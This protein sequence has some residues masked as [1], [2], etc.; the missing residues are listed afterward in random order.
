MLSSVLSA[1]EQCSFPYLHEQPLSVTDLGKDLDDSLLKAIDETHHPQGHTCE[2]R[3]T[4]GSQNSFTIHL[5][6]AR[7]IISPSPAI[8]SGLDQLMMVP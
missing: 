8:D 1:A 5:A 4:A 7:G 3:P 6:I 2:G